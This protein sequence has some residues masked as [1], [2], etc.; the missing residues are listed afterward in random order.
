MS[1]QSG[2]QG[3]VAMDRNRKPDDASGL[4]IDVVAAVDAKQ[5]PAAPFDNPDEVPAGCRFHAGNSNIRSIPPGS[6]GSTS[7][8]RHPS[9]ASCRFC[10]SSSMLSPCVAQPG[11][12]G[13]SAQ[14][15]PSSASCTTIL[16]FIVDL[17]TRLSPG[18][19]ANSS[20]VCTSLRRLRVHLGRHLPNRARQ[21]LGGLRA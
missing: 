14:K 19:S 11:M 2:F 15:P 16:I 4:A 3:L 7:I 17:Q 9:I 21:L 10:M 5:G 1:Q 20:A 12:A 6:G 13:T 18:Y 8:E